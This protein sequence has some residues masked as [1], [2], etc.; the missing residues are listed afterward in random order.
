MLFTILPWLHLIPANKI[1]SNWNYL[2]N[3]C[4]FPRLTA[5]LHN[6][7][8][9]EI[10][11]YGCLM[12]KN[13][14]GSRWGFGIL[15]GRKRKSYQSKLIGNKPT[16]FSDFF[17]LQLLRRNETGEEWPWK[18]PEQYRVYRKIVKDILILGHVARKSQ[19]RDV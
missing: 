6:F 19:N 17:P 11:Q 10:K 14:F 1:I 18:I 3:L 9:L 5:V 4:L 13:T 15:F 8:S 16:A 2:L 12:D 7:L